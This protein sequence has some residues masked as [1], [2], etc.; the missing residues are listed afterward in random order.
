MASTTAQDSLVTAKNVGDGTTI[1]LLDAKKD[2]S[3][4][5]STSGTVTDGLVAVEASQD[6][7][8]WVVRHLFEV[9]EG[10]TEGYD[11]RFG[12]YRYWRASVRRAVAGGGTVKVTLMEGDR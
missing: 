10:V 4:V 1:D 3:A 9:Q 11:S 2:V 8:N 5:I 7:T 6:G 12:A